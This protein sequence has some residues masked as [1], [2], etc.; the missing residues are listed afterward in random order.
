MPGYCVTCTDITVS[1]LTKHFACLSLQQRA[2]ILA[3]SQDA[4]TDFFFLKKKSTT[5]S[6]QPRGRGE[7]TSSWV[8]K[9]GRGFT[10][11]SKRWHLG[12]EPGVG[13]HSSRPLREL[14]ARAVATSGWCASSSGPVS[15][16]IFLSNCGLFPFT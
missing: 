16:F 1:A 3:A 2:P 6:P 12:Q 5:C 9:R 15:S 10:L 7:G 14:G 11:G 4:E 13:F 8:L